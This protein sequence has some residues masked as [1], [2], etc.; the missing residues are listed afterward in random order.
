MRPEI[1]SRFT[2]EMLAR[3]ASRYGASPDDLEMLDGFESFIYRFGKDRQGNILRIGHSGRRGE[4]YVRGEIDWINFLAAGGTGVARAVPSID[5]NLVETTADGS[6]EHFIAAVF[7]EA[8][9]KY[10]GEVGWSDALIEN[11]GRVI[12]RMHALTTQYQPGDPLGS[13]PHWYEPAINDVE[14]VLA[15]VDPVAA[16]KWA[17]L[18]A[19]IRTLQTP[20][21]AYGLIH[22]DA[23]A[24]NFFVDDDLRITFFDFDDCCYNWFSADIAIVLFYKV[25]WDADRAAAAREFLGPFLRGYRSEYRL[26][27]KWLETMPLF[28][29]MREIDLYAL[30]Q[31]DFDLETEDD[32]WIVGYMKGR[33]E[34]IH[35]DRP[36]IDMDFRNL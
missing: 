34:A 31:R 33:R 2:N 7:R 12:G 36:Y 28:L 10:P 26:D 35:E 15:E 20:G 19:E 4:T 1:K 14:D 22:Y 8:S 11:Y 18:L 25:M 13:R 30:I 24:L 29:K 21:D 3:L 32:P 9:G 23:H 16:E 17:R 5:G 27:P 6:G